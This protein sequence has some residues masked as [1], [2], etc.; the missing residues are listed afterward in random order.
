MGKKRI[1][2]KELRKQNKLYQ[3]DIAQN[4][5]ISPSFYSAIE[6]GE[7]NPTLKLAKNIAD[8][9][10]TTVEEIFLKK[11]DTIWNDKILLNVTLNFK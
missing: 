10:G 2:L 8:L 9:L 3:K 11:Q 7:R 4:L 6:R 5:D 1:R